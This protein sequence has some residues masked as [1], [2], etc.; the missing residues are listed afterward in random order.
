[1]IICSYS[2]FGDYVSAV[3][4]Q[5]FAVNSFM[6]IEKFSGDPSNIL[7]FKGFWETIKLS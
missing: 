1:M 5:V 7:D 3:K 2:L 4:V 6:V